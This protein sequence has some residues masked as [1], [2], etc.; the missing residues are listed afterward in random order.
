MTDIDAVLFDLFETLITV[1]HARLKAISFGDNLVPSTAG[2]V[3]S[4]LRTAAPDFS[5]DALIAAMAETRA[6][7]QVRS[8][9]N[10]EIPEHHFF[11][12][13][14]P[15][16]GLADPGDI[17]ARRLADAQMAAIVA[18]CR[19]M[20]GARSLLAS[21]R[22]RGIRTGVVSN[23][24]H[25][26]SLDALLA[27]VDPE[28]RFDA[29][30]ASIEVGFCKPDQR[31]F[32][33]ALARLKIDSN[34]TLHVGDDP[35]DDVAGAMHAGIRPVWFNPSGRLWPYAGERPTTVWAFEEIETLL[36]PPGS[37]TV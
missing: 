25:A 27:I 22:R 28:H 14:L 31:P 1:D 2:T 32:Q 20:P 17:L 10:A 9:P 26:Q 30:V 18:A 16:L 23:L 7:P 19:P 5:K 8:E 6:Q 3:L 13:L 29:A 11:I 12:A 34:R 35:R 4:L 21:L 33:M 15:R 36:G 24:A 37:P